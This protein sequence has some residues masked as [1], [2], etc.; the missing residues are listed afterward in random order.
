MLV[1]NYI[2]AY[3]IWLAT[4]FFG[5]LSIVGFIGL[6]VYAVI[7]VIITA[8]K[9]ILFLIISAILLVLSGIIMVCDGMTKGAT[10]RFIYK[11]FIACENSPFSWYKNSRYDLG[12][13]C[14]R[15]FF[16][17]LNCFGPYDP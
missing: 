7:L 8:M 13:K 17:S 16:C 10:S 12:N 1:Y 4:L 11:H 15:G 2:P 14:Q 5:D 6:L 3:G 9:S